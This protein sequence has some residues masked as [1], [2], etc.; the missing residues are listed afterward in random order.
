MIWAHKTLE[1][2]FQTDCL[3]L[4]G[5]P[6]PVL[7]PRDEL[8][9][10]VPFCSHITRNW[11]CEL[12]CP[13]SCT[14]YHGT[15]QWN[16]GWGQ[17]GVVYSLGARAS[18]SCITTFPVS[19]NSQLQPGLLVHHR[20]TTP[21]MICMPPQYSCPSPANARERRLS[22]YGHTFEKQSK[23]FQKT[24]NIKNF[25]NLSCNSTCLHCCEVFRMLYIYW[26]RKMPWRRVWQPTP[27]FLPG[28]SPRMK[29]P[30]GLQSL[31]SQR[32]GHD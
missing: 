8:H 5:P 3:S 15:G 28:E 1:L 32:V 23:G 2:F 16:L 10:W 9:S 11:V 17:K 31:G 13:L 25:S 6:P 18:S 14:T 7:S 21:Y 24:F 30:G 20:R 27:V 12:K 19:S 29:E 4:L 22:G 26:I